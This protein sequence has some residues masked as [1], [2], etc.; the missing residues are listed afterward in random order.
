MSKNIRGH[1]KQ[2]SNK[3]YKSKSKDRNNIKGTNIWLL[4]PIIF[5]ISVLPFIMKLKEYDTNLSKFTWFTYNDTYVDFF[6]KYKQTFFLIMVFIMAVIALFKAY[7]DKKSI[8]YSRILIPLAVYGALALLS[9]IFSKY[10]RYSFAGI[11]EHFESIFVLLGYC[12][13]VYYCLQIVK[14]EWDVRII[15]NCF[16]VSVIVMSLLGLTQY[17]GKD[18]F[19]TDFGLKMIL[20]KAH[21]STR[22]TV[23]FN[24]EKNRVYLTFY[25]PNYVGSYAAM[26]ASF[27]LVLA[28]LTR[29]HKRMIPIYLL[30]VAG[31]SISLLGSKS[32]TGIIGLAL[33]LLL[34]LIILSRYLL[35]YFYLSIPII[36]LLLSIVVLYNKANDN[37]LIDR[38]I[39]VTN[40]KKSE[41]PALRD[42]ITA[43]DEVIINYKDNQL[44]L[45]YTIEDNY[46][47]FYAFDNY[48]NSV[49]LEYDAETSEFTIL[50]ERFPGF[51]LGISNYDDIDL[52]Y[53]KINNNNWYFTNQISNGGYYHLNKYGKLD[54][55]ITAPH[56][57]FSGYEKYASGRGYIWSRTL[58]L[59]KNRIILGSG[60]DT[61]MIV[62]PQEDHVGLYNFGY[63]DQLLTKPHNL[64]LQV[65]VQTGVL[66]LVAFLVFYAMYFISSVKLYIKGKFKSYYAQVGVAILV[67]SISYMLLGLAN[68]SSLT[69]APIF[70]TL[71]G[72]GITVNRL[73][74]P[75]I[76]EELAAEKDAIKDL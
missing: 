30:A 66:S 21:W 67:A 3:Y 14:T 15:V 45:Q 43:D 5:I 50:D 60:A 34:A 12:L 20:P 16:V 56:A 49:P 73:A 6:L 32:K 18:F 48:D 22:D 65:G 55:I 54:K 70:W 11:H 51:R 41:Q 44:H 46:G 4:L 25:N 19:A 24:F 61:F 17:I 62:F 40:F 10:R 28:A 7:T 39:Q 26:A 29:K 8:I 71:I 58:P 47:N 52:F 23:D 63:G 9:S 57:V 72:L 27:F 33:A 75:Y 68:D 42:I 69:V 1:N 64:Y 2:S 35:K 31:I 59:L 37:M 76:N 13:I 38:I 53:V 36:L 74:K